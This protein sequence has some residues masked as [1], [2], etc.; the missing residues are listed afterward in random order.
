MSLWDVL[1]THKI[2]NN[3]SLVHRYP[4]S[5]PVT[6]AFI[7]ARRRK[8]QND[9]TTKGV[10]PLVYSPRVETLE[11]SIS[12]NKT[13][14]GRQAT[15][16]ADNIAQKDDNGNIIVNIYKLFINLIHYFLYVN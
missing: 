8:N 16:A 12:N 7:D 14:N 6:P 1:A 13:I 2:E 15:P 10:F 5:L 4:A 11:T 3:V 9:I